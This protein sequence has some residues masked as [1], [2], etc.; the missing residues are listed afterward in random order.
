MVL[1]E[2]ELQPKRRKVAE[3]SVSPEQ[4]L[5][6]AIDSALE[7]AQTA[8][9]RAGETV[10]R[11]QPHAVLVPAAAGR[12]ESRTAES[13]SQPVGNDSLIV[14]AVEA[15]AA[16]FSAAQPALV[17]QSLLARFEALERIVKDQGSTISVLVAKVDLWPRQRERC[18]T[19][20]R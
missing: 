13:W 8:V 10:G 14:V 19:S 16:T 9:I 18:G 12:E 6:D 1:I 3:V 7:A 15:A 2:V 5:Q 11:L 4:P 20:S 17:D